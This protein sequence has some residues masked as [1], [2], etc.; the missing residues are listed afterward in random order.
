[1]NSS[2]IIFLVSDDVRCVSV[3]YEPGG[4]STMFKTLDS[5]LDVDD[6]VV[7][8]TG[9]RYNF[10]VGKITGIDHE[11]DFNSS[12]DIRWVVQRVDTEAFDL[13]LGQETT[14]I[15]AVRANE[16]K[17]ERAKLREELFENDEELKSLAF[18]AESSE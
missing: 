5:D 14:A 3:Q 7:V 17:R 15:K 8:E 6:L 2:R 12:A 1:M 9:T 10:T 4:G 18:D 13:I 16:L 11:P